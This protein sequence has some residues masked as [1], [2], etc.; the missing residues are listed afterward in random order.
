MSVNKVILVG[1]VGKDPEVKYFDNDVSVAHFPLATSETFTRNGEKVT[2]TEWHNVTV[3]RGL[4][5]V[6]ENYV[7]KGMQLY[8]EGSLRTRS[9]DDQDGNKR[10]TTEIV[11]NSLQ[12]LGKKGDNENNPSPADTSVAKESEAATAPQDDDDLP[13]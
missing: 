2:Q 3:W 6:A 10:Y 8:I 5:K 7:K 11:A 1:N 13:F 4:A 9:W 12:M